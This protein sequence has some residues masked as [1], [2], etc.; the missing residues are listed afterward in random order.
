[1]LGDDWQDSS[2][3]GRGIADH[4]D[5]LNEEGSGEG[6]ALVDPV[7]GGI[8][9]PTTPNTVSPVRLKA[10]P[11]SRNK[12]SVRIGFANELGP[13]V[14][15]ALELSQDGTVLLEYKDLPVDWRNNEHVL[16]G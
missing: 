1:M 8:A 11:L 9:D 3:D 6:N 16:T 15:E 12:S 5:D 7:L 2:K 14:A 4:P 13:S 10:P